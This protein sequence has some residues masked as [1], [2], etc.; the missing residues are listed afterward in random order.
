MILGWT[1]RYIVSYREYDEDFDEDML[2]EDRLKPLEQTYDDT[3]PKWSVAAAVSGGGD[4]F[5]P[6]DETFY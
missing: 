6:N 2:I 5:N 1:K 4:T 3:G